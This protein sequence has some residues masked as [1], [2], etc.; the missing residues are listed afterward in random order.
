MQR[1]LPLRLV[2]VIVMGGIVLAFIL[3]ALFPSSET[4]E[5]EELSLVPRM[6]VLLSSP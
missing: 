6:Y 2:E 3:P 1:N 4:P 5:Q